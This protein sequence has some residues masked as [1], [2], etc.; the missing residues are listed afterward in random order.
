MDGYKVCICWWLEQIHWVS[1]EPA[2]GSILKL[3]PAPGGTGS[4]MPS[5]AKPEHFKR[6]NRLSD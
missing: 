5:L 3:I 4:V 6:V 1:L 2:C